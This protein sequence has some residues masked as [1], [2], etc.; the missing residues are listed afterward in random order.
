VAALDFRH[1]PV[2]GSGAG[3]FVREWYRH[4]HIRVDVQDA[5][6][7][8]LETLAEL[9]L[10]GLAALGC[11]L[12]VPAVAAWRLRRRPLVAGAFG[13]YAAFVAHAAVDWD[14]E[15]PAVTLAGLFCGALLVAA[16]RNEHSALVLEGRWRAPLL[17]PVLALLAFS[18]VG[19]VGNRAQASA[20][21]AAWRSDWDATD[22][23]ARRAA[24]WAPWSA[25]AL[26][27]RATVA[28]ARHDPA[29]ARSLLLRASRKDA[30][31]YVV[32]RRLAAVSA[33]EQSVRAGQRA[34]LLNPLG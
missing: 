6:S 1:H 9:G 12:A 28:S 20:V 31:D 17:I 10:V 8:Y 18:F 3:T 33:G 5:H 30:S 14:W 25:D 7:L 2:A 21:D 13:A 27:L 29:A 4:R 11:F 23:A 15:L 16:A 22:A 19:L 26:V 24:S 32:W 34:A